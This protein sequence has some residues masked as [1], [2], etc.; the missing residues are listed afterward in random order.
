M[1]RAD[2]LK[3]RRQLEALADTLPDEKAA[4]APFLSRAWEPDGTYAVDDRRRY[5]DILYKCITAHEALNDPNRAPDLAHSLWTP[6]ADPSEDGSREHP[7]HW[8]QGMEIHNGKYYLENGVLY[9][10]TRDSGIGM[11]FPLASLIGQYVEVVAE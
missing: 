10:G 11:S 3:I 8:V 2:A 6:I 7:I 4:S 1:R 5:G 9:R